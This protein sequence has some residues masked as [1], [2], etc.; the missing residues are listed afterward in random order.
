MKLITIILATSLLLPSIALAQTVETYDLLITN[1]RIIDGTGNP[2]FRGSVGIRDGKIVKVGRVVN[3]SAKQ[4]IDAQNQVVAPG[5]IDVH[6]HTE[7]IFGNPTAENFVRMGVTSLITGN[8]GGSETDVA[9]FLGRYKEKPL[10][11]NLATLIGHNSVR[12]KVMGLDNRAPT[13]DEQAKMNAVV[14]QAMKDGAVG[15]STGLIYLPGT[16]AKTEEV[17]ELAKAASKYGGTYASHIRNEEARVVDA[18]KEAINI[19]EQANMPV[20]ISHFKISAKALWG[21]TP[22]T[23]GLVKAARERG[24]TVTVDQYAYTASSTS[25]DSRMPNW[26]LAGGRAEGRKR[27]TDPATR[28]KIVTEMKKELKERGFKDY[29]YAYVASFRDKPEFNGKNIA[30]ITKQVRG[31]NKVDDQIDQILEMYDKGG[32]SMVY[33]TMNE[34]DVQNIMREPFTMIASDSG[35]REFGSGVPHPR[36]YGNNARVL[37]HY[38]RDLKVVTLEDAIRKMT[39]LPAQTFNLRDRGQLREG[40]AADL[41]IFD[42]AT[43]GD[44]AT[45]EQPHQ[46]AVGFSSVVVNGQVIFDGTKLTGVMSGQPLYGNKH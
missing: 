40:F 7:D 14:E 33:R 10:A 4:T 31:K 34:A 26:A 6:A 11:V 12:S 18:I 3:A 38:V 32:A 44:K 46:Y 30:E 22:M 2:W 28:A 36:G 35:V 42:P 41:V 15:L 29:S 24:L 16:F 39:S 27:I 20:E 1:A 37:G 25:L 9:E 43:I 5:F 13:A 8:C 45:F 21:E 19:G 23:I 17:V